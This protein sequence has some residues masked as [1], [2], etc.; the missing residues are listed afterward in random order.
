MA[1][2]K[3]KFKK[4]RALRFYY[5][6]LGLERLHYGLWA[7]SDERTLEGVKVAQKRYED[8]L[9]GEIES[10][11]VDPTRS[12]VLD[13]GCGSGIMS[14]TL[15]K[16]KYQVEGLS[17][18]MYQKEV[19]E[20]RI[21]VDFHLARFQNFEPQKE[22]D[23]VLMS[24]SAQ[25][26]P[27]KRL[28]AKAKECL[29]SNGH[30]LVCDYFTFDNACGPMAKSGHKLTAFMQM[31]EENGFIVKKKRDITAETTPTLDAARIFTEKYIL[32][33]IEIFSDKMKERRPK[34][35][36]FLMW[37]FRKKIDKGYKNLIL[38]DSEEFAKNKSYMYF[39]LQKNTSATTDA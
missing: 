24:E 10:V 19:F 28:F 25:Y 27:L 38:L 11:A 36:K 30:L 21:P 33:S 4:D 26:I 13:V 2:K 39:L 23:V 32:P 9:V 17:P 5:D 37:I 35:L 31:A 14:E 8:F 7:D 6:V 16:K 22:Y 18:D 20:K 12:K 34:L 15:H 3:E 29:T 1:K